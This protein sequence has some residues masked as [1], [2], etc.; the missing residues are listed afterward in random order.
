MWNLI[1]CSDPN[2]NNDPVIEVHNTLISPVVQ[3]AVLHLHKDTYTAALLVT[4]LK[5]TGYGNGISKNT[6]C[7]LKQYSLISL[8]FE[9]A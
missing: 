1:G 3:I 7:R 6:A 4:F 8:Q 5:L 9:A 2:S